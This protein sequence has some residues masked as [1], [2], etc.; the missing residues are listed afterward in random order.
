LSGAGDAHGDRG[1]A[2]EGDAVGLSPEKQEAGSKKQ[3]DYEED[4][5]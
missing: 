2:A 1:G 3:E 4:S 5:Y